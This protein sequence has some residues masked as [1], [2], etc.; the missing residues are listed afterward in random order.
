M[1]GLIDGGPVTGLIDGHFVI[2]TVDGHL[3]VDREHEPDVALVDQLVEIFEEGGLPALG[4]DGQLESLATVGDG[5]TAR[6][7]EPLGDG[8]KDARERRRARLDG[9]VRRVLP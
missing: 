8:R 5:L 6:G 7:R 1:T 4:R 2:G 3:V 9:D